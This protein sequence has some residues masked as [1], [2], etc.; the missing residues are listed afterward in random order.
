M[1]RVGIDL[2][3][4]TRFKNLISRYDSDTLLYLYTAAEQ[5]HCNFV[6]K[7]YGLAISFSGKES[8]GKALGV[9]LAGLNW[10]DIQIF[11][12]GDE[13][14]DICLTGE[15]LKLAE[16]LLIKQWNGY[17]NLL[18]DNLCVTAVITGSQDLTAGD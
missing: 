12:Q 13:T 7:E 18:S 10:F 4:I 16:N 17:W 1:M 15:A 6:N 8:V 3:E 11:P 9:G 5:K 14:L 2:L